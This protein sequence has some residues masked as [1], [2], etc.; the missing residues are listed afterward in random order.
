MF[1]KKR[2][3]ND[4]SIKEYEP[5]VFINKPATSYSQDVVGFKS[6]IETIHQAIENGANMIGVAAD[7]GTGK[8]TISDILISDVLS[9]ERKYSSIRINMWDSISDKTDDGVSELTKSFLYQLANGNNDVDSVSKLSRYASK[10]MSKNFNSISFSTISNKLWKSGLFA[11]IMY[12][13]YR[14]FSQDSLSFITENNK[15]FFELIKDI[16]PVFLIGAIGALIYGIMDTSIAFSSWNKTNDNHLEINDV[17]ELY[18]EISTKLVENSN[19]NKQIIFIEDLDRVPDKKSVKIFLKEL[20]RF[21]NSVSKEVKEQFVFIVAIKPE[22]LLLAPSEKSRPFEH[23]YSKVFDVTINLKPIHFADYESALLA[24]LDKNNEAKIKLERLIGEQI[25]EK[26]LPKSFDWILIGEN[27]TLRDLKD[28]LNHAISIMV[29]LKNKNYK[30]VSNISFTACTAVSYLESAFSIEFYELVQKEE[31][32]EAFI[33]NSYPIKNGSSENK[34]DDLIATFKDVFGETVFTEEFIKVLCNLVL[35]NILDDDFRMY[36]YTYPDNSYVK[37]VDE[38]DVCNLI[39]LPTVFNN[40]EHLDEK[41][42]R[43]FKNRPNSI[44]V[45]TI[46]NINTEETYPLVLLLNCKLFEIAVTHNVDQALELL[47][48]YTLKLET[49]DDKILQYLTVVNNSPLLNKQE[50]ISKFVEKILA[51]ISNE[52]WN[53]DDIIKLRKNILIAFS[54]DNLSF[55]KLFINSEIDIPLLTEEEMTEIETISTILRLTNTELISKDSDYIF[56]AINKSKLLE[57]DVEIAIEVYKALIRNVDVDEYV[58][59]LLLDFLD[60]N[61]MLD[62]ELFDIILKNTKSDV[63]ICKYV[64]SFDAESLPIEYLSGLN[65][66]A[67]SNGLN[68]NILIRLKENDLYISYLLTKTP[69]NQIDDIEYMDENVSK[70]ILASCDAILNKDK[71]VFVSLRH[72]I[73]KKSQQVYNVYSSIFQA[74][75]PVITKDEL[76]TFDNFSNAIICIDGSQLNINNCDF[77]WEY[78]NQDLRSS[79]ECSKIFDYLFNPQYTDTMVR[80]SITA[81]KIFYSFD[82]N[83]IKFSEL[84]EEE[85]ETSISYLK[86]FLKL[87]EVN[88]ALKCMYHTYT[89][90]PSL[91]KIVQGAGLADKYIELLN[92]LKMVTATSINWFKTII[93]KVALCPEITSRLYEEGIYTNYVI[94]K[95]LYENKLLYDKELLS[96]EE[97]FNI[98][99]KYNSMFEIMSN[100]QEFIRDIVDNGLYKKLTDVTLIKPLF[101]IPQTIEIMQFIWP[102]LSGNMYDEYIMS[103]PEISTLN[104]SKAIKEFLCISENMD[105]LNS[106]QLKNKIDHLLWDDHK[107]HKKQFNVAW[108]KVWKPTLGKLDNHL[109]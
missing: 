91:E 46:N 99:I 75:Y 94:G 88:E 53:E 21:Q 22:A 36:F 17:F 81:N 25:S 44:V 63:E 27:L 50:F 23:L 55:K 107:T 69:L 39:K 72:N 43:I 83:K 18:D 3:N 8:S 97:Y 106:Y 34:T 66:R 87:T 47:C 57:Q 77:V 42:E 89:L 38:K 58:G 19:Y 90:I 33:R 59:N 74:P 26:H 98:Y 109:L 52:T 24:M 29:S 54:Y 68:E 85:K 11:T 92:K 62:F 10:R 103:I 32:F 13:I 28:R 71:D 84:S 61:H 35:D 82:F 65:K 104:D 14:I 41:V 12:A 45:D 9:N 2:I 48:N 56:K 105:K 1:K 64:N 96:I 67:I 101:K 86:T 60:V 5:I 70:N 31:K 16:H 100:N 102:I 79:D 30:E 37:T 40:F 95:S 76:N 78:C 20:Y 4:N 80:D 73:I 6:Q 51:C 93:V 49:P 7:Y 15:N 108:N